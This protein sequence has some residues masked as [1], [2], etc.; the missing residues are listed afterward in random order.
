VPTQR[1]VAREAAIERLLA[2]RRN[3]EA[4]GASLSPEEELAALRGPLQPNVKSAIER[5]G[6]LYEDLSTLLAA[7]RT[8][9]DAL[10]EDT[11][12]TADQIE[13]ELRRAD[14]RK[15]KEIEVLTDAKKQ[16]QQQQQ[17]V[18]QQQQHQQK[19]APLDPAALKDL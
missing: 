8:I 11:K 2:A 7:G 1:E 15:R 3:A 19:P 4:R 13:E 5:I 10:V 16:Q 18:D 6:Q 14:E 12:K 9:R 17:Q